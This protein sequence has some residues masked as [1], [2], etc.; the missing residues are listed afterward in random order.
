MAMFIDPRHLAQFAVIV[1]L[2]SFTRAAEALGTTQPA[3]SKM[4]SQLEDRLGTAILL[5]RRGPVLPS[6]LGARLVA[7]GNAI[8]AATQA[9]AASVEAERTG[10]EG[11]LRIG[12][13]GFFCEHAMPDLILGFRGERPGVQVELRS[14]YRDDLLLMIEEQRIDLAFTPIEIDDPHPSVSTIPLQPLR[15]VVIGRAGHTLAAQ[16]AVSAQDLSRAS[17]V[18]QMENS[19][20]YS[21]MMRWLTGIGAAPV[22]IELRSD[23][24]SMLLAAITHTDCLTVLPL[25]AALPGLRQGRLS[26]LRT[27]DLPSVQFGVTH[28]AAVTPSPAGQAFISAVRE[29]FAAGRDQSDAYLRS[30]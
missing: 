26:V 7:R 10:R 5:Q 9:A 25:F 3:L 15:H 20:L 24:S 28:H 1:E 6:S 22:T 29:S 13:P 30:I 4:V 18:G 2:G 8:R 12:A 16:P 17:W 27:A 23:S 19:T 14:G 11:L 21:V